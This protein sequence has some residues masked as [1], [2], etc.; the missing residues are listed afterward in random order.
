[1]LEPHLRFAA[2]Q[3]I[4]H[5]DLKCG[6]CFCCAKGIVKLGDFGISRALTQGEEMAKTFVGTPYYMSPELLQ[7]CLH[8]LSC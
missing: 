2:A 4:I 5:R 1:M 7:V 3:G 8:P 6:N